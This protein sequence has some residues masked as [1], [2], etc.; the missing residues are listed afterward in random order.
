MDAQSQERALGLI[1]PSGNTVI[2]REFYRLPLTGV[3]WH[4]TRI[5][6]SEDTIEQLAA[7]KGAAAAAAQL[8]SHAGVDATAFG[9]TNGSFLGGSDYDDSIVELM[10]ASGAKTCVTTSGSVVAALKTLGIKRPGLFT[11]Y[12]DEITRLAV[13]YLEQNDLAPAGYA[14]LDI[15]TLMGMAEM[16]QDA[17]SDWV[18]SRVPDGSDGI[19]ISCTNFGRMDGI[20]SLERRTGLPVVTSNQAT[21]WNLLHVS[22]ATIPSGIVPSRLFAD[23]PG[24]S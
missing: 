24:A 4:F 15:K 5:H 2:E 9:C 18:A 17:I 6:S 23:S 21:L 13:T 22:Q 12:N 19:F 14:C 10:R 1:V 20:A 11:P 8:L 7:M 16:S 3:R